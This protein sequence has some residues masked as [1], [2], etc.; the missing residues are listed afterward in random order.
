MAKTLCPKGQWSSIIDFYLVILEYKFAQTKDE[1][2]Y[3]Y[4]RLLTLETALP[5]HL[6]DHALLMK[7]RFEKRLK[8]VIT[9]NPLQ[10]KHPQWQKLWAK[11]KDASEMWLMMWKNLITP[12]FDLLD[13]FYPYQ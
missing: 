7:L 8:L 10:L 12:R 3:I 9:S 2:G 11:E 5:A 4:K 6:Q 1:L 13:V